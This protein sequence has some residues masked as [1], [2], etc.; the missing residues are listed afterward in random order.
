MYSAIVTF[1]VSAL[2][3]LLLPYHV[4][5][6]IK[7]NGCDIEN[8]ASGKLSLDEINTSDN[9]IMNSKLTINSE[10]NPSNVAVH[11]KINDED[12]NSMMEQNVD[13]CSLSTDDMFKGYFL[14]FDSPDF[15][16]GNCPVPAGTYTSGEYEVSISDSAPE[17]RYTGIFEIIDETDIIFRIKCSV[18]I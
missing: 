6:D 14:S 11:I 8:I 17:G 7:L 3:A 15:N 9:G 1:F 12:G 18:E 4:A 2:C 10:L 13:I 5:G 16:E